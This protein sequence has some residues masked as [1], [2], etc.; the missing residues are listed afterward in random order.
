VSFA[1]KHKKFT[2]VFR[3]HLVNYAKDFRPFPFGKSFA[4]FADVTDGELRRIETELEAMNLQYPPQI[5]AIRSCQPADYYEHIDGPLLTTS[6]GHR[7]SEL[8]VL[9]STQGL[10]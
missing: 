1:W 2:D 5:Q 10:V 4:E 9:L 8:D 6:D 7:V 3:W